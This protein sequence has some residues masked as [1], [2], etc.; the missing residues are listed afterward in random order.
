MASSFQVY[1]RERAEADKDR[2]SFLADEIQSLSFAEEQSGPAIHSD[3]SPTQLVVAQV[4]EGQE[5]GILFRSLLK[6]PGWSLKKAYRSLDPAAQELIRSEIGAA[7]LESFLRLGLFS[8]GE[9]L[10]E[11]TYSLVKQLLRSKK[12]SQ[13]IS[14]L[15][16]L[17][18]QSDSKEIATASNSLLK[19]LHGKGSGP[20]QWTHSVGQALDQF[21]D[22]PS[23]IGMVGGGLAF[24]GVRAGAL[25]ILQG[26]L[27][28]RGIGGLWAA[29]GLANSAALLSEACVFPTTTKLARSAFLQ[30]VNWDSKLWSDEVLGTAIVLGNI[31]LFGWGGRI[32]R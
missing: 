16:L 11:A 28:S 31:R 2:F 12:V 19:I 10:W 6:N 27:G 32:L 25:K 8:E 22:L 15:N 5:N 30:E 1:G 29:R 23:F 21:S 18:Q 13:G 20:S 7:H 24:K 9:K 3:P 14:L 4:M 17:S 26:P